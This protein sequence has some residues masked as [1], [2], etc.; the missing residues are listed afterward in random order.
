M[1]ILERIKEVTPQKDKRKG[2]IATAIGVACG[3]VLATGLVVNP[4]GIIA[5]TVG[6]AIFGGKALFHAQKVVK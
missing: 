5:L 1:N 4:I 2:K 6:A 3:A